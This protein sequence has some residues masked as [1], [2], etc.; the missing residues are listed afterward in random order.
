MLMNSYSIKEIIEETK[1]RYDSKDI[2][3]LESLGN[4]ENII[5]TYIINIKKIRDISIAKLKLNQLRT[6]SSITA[7]TLSLTEEEHIKI[8][9]YIDMNITNKIPP[10]YILENVRI[11]NEVYF[12]NASVLIPRSDT[13][14]LISEVVKLINKKDLKSMLDICTGSGIIGISVANNSEIQSVLMS[15]ISDKAIEVAKINIQKNGAESKCSIKR[16]DMFKNIQGLFDCITA[17][18]PYIETEKLEKL[19]DYVKKEPSLALDG[20]EDGLNFYHI[21]YKEARRCLN[22]NAY[23]AVEIGYNQAE[24]VVNIIKKYSE[25]SEIKV[26]KD[27]SSKDRVVICRFHKI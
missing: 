26:I 27:L 21:L 19:S 12:V 8:M 6:I 4:L 16:S 10:Q 20:G 15:D 22:N 17:N 7:A 5:Y 9:E 11:Y 24:S 18:P 1:E 14:V 23:I 13:E 2:S 25:Y 3:E